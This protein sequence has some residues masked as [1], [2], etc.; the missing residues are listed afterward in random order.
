M[1][2]QQTALV[3]DSTYSGNACEQLSSRSLPWPS[4]R[5]TYDVAVG[6]VLTIRL[7]P[8]ID[9]SSRRTLRR[10]GDAHRTTTAKEMF[11]TTYKTYA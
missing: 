4:R 10:S 1:G 7:Y 6:P 3:K 8:L 11:I 5:M 2:T 9:R